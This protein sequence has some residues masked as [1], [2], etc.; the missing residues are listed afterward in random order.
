MTDTTAQRRK[1]LLERR[2]REQNL[3]AAPEASRPV[4]EPGTPSPL[5][6][7]QRRM[8]F[9]QNLNPADTTLNVCVGYRLVGALDV[10]KLRAALESVVAANEILRTVYGVD[11]AGEPFQLH[12]AAAELPWRYEDLA[13]ATDPS[14]AADE[15]A[16]V[17][18]GRPFDLAVDVPIRASLVRTGVDEHVLVL[19]VHHVA[20]D[21]ASWPAF[22]AQVNAAY[23]G[24]LS[25]PSGQYVDVALAVP[26]T[27]AADL[28]YWTAVLTP[29]PPRLELPGVRGVSDSRAARTVARQLPAEL[30]DRV[31]ALARA[32]ATTPFTVLL[33]AFEAAVQRYTAADDFLVSIPVV[34][35]GPGA[36]E[37]IGYFGNT[38]LLRADVHAAET[39]TD[40]VDRVREASAGAFAHQGAGVDEVVREVNPD[41][42]GGRDAIAQLVAVSFSNRSAANGFDFDAV[43]ATELPWHSPVAAEELGLLIV[44]DGAGARVEATY[45]TA[46]LDS[47]LVEQFLS[48]YVRLL[49]AAVADPRQPLRDIDIL[50]AAGRADLLAASYGQLVDTPATTIVDVLAR[51][52][53]VSPDA[54]AV[55]SDNERLTYAQ[56]NAR[57]NQLAHWMIGRGVGA[58]DVVAL[59]LATSVE[60]I[61]ATAAVLKAGA[62][63]LPIDPAYPDDRIDYLRSDAEP[64]LELDADSYAVAL[65]EAAALSDADPTDADRVRPLRAANTAYVIYTSGSTGRPKGVPVP[66]NAIA[67]HLLGFDAEWELTPA[68]RVLQS[69]SVSFDASLLDIYVTLTA[70]ATVVV[71]KPNA[72]RDIA[73]VA[74]LVARERVTVLHMVPSM[75]ATLLMLPQAADWSSLRHLPVGGEALSG[76]VADRFATQ[77]DAHLR[78]HYGPTEAVVSSTH[79]EVVEPQSV[80]IVPIGVPNQNVSLHLLDESLRL[81]PNGVCGEIYLGGNQLARGYLDRAELTSQRFVADPFVHGQRLYRTGD[82]ARRNIKGEIEFLG[83]ADEQVKIR[84]FRIEL[85]EVSKRISEHPDV[86][87]AVVV[88][89]DHPVSGPALAAYV[90]GTA[91]LAAV[92]SYVAERLPEHMV[93]ASFVAIDEV[94]LTAHGKLDKRALPEVELIEASAYRQPSTPTE[95]RIAGLF[96]TLFGIERVGA[97]DSF[98]DLGGHSMLAA[99]LI[100]MIRSEFGFELDLRV[101]FDHPTVSAL[102][103]VLVAM[104]LDEFGLDLDDVDEFGPESDEAPAVDGP[105][106]VPTVRERPEYPPLSYSQRAYWLQRRME[107]P[108]DGENVTFPIR[109]EGPLDRDALFAALADVVERH[110]SLRT[111]FPEHEGTPYQRVHPVAPLDIPVIDVDSEA[112]LDREL[113]VDAKYVF[114]LTAESSLRLR[115]LVRGDDDCVLSILMHHIIADRSSCEVFIGDLMTAYAARSAG[116]QPDWAPLEVQF[117]AFAIWQREVFDR[118]GREVSTVG[119]AQLDFWRAKLDGLPEEI[120]VGHDRPRP[121]VLGHHGNVAERRVPARVWQ[122]ALGMADSAAVTPFMLCHAIGVTVMNALGA[123]E[124]L[125]IGAAVANRLSEPTENVVGL[126]ANVIV[127]R[128]DLSADP[129]PRAL[130]D[131]VRESSLDS[132]GHQGVPFERLVE[133]LNPKRSLSR[134]PLCQTMMHVRDIPASENFT[135]DGAITYRDV[136]KFYEVSFMDVHF[137]YQLE[138][139]GDLVL[140]VITNTD[141]YDAQTG[142]FFVDTAVNVL[143]AFVEQ[144]DTPLSQLDVLP[145]QWDSSRSVVIH[146]AARSVAPVVVEVTETTDTE[147]RL[148]ALLEEL[149]EI[150]GVTRDDGFFALGGDSVIAIGWAARAIQ[151]GLPLTPRMVFEHFTIDELAAVVDDAIAHPEKYADVEADGAAVAPAPEPTAPMSVSGLGADALAA[152]KDSFAARK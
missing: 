135:A 62:A 27:G 20:W 72:F 31:G 33:A 77:F 68:D 66:H 64:V 86:A 104:F 94:P 18:F 32:H 14:A 69:T 22:F 75:L 115:L 37:L 7:A 55:V 11:A 70:G 47:G 132:L 65:A 12:R 58:E 149:L 44:A 59:R 6:A 81:T 144:S 103:E 5:S 3:K 99:R 101:P 4:R 39:F 113:D 95:I 50:G 36:E 88:V 120:N 2:L 100:T 91:D 97:D 85:G 61:V 49:D 16:R 124:D 40:L 150:D 109:L 123:G 90:V 125:A 71:P 105:G 9:V 80:G 119:E 30:V 34:D 143:G 146:R 96:A 29:L 126:F 133:T 145:G 79:M 147:R 35:R 67:E 52:V 102:A 140:R 137:D 78:N 127:V 152:L 23:R 25:A 26:D 122:R 108:I 41:R 148:I 21:D 116:A 151:E 74:D 8:W 138:R 51:S 98:F 106:S 114:D 76:E 92:R 93:P 142:E 19:V 111:T 110:E 118:V 28:E 15:F 131:R 128:S 82:L 141:L 24:V 134:N 54:E 139:S 53:A 57:A 48:H 10:D 63:Y 117:V 38:V 130:L 42:A 87:H 136:S 107:G 89:V 17:Q 112:E 121:P 56:F 129:T 84:G 73:H 83:R 1:A 60:F 46:A 43:T 45:Q 13:S